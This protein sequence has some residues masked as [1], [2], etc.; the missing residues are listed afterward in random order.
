MVAYTEDTTSESGARAHAASDAAIPP[1]G[2]IT[3]DARLCSAVTSA[4]QPDNG[5]K[6]KATM[7][8]WL[9]ELAPDH[10]S[11]LEANNEPVAAEMTC[12]D[13]AIILLK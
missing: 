13:T 11:G 6:N 7:G 3:K 9:N 5:K 10:R 2:V 8:R 12:S 1:Y 4:I